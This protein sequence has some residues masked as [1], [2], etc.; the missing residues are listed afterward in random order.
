MSKLIISLSAFLAL[1]LPAFAASLEESNQ[2]LEKAWELHDSKWGL[3]CAKQFKKWLDLKPD[4]DQKYYILAKDGLANCWYYAADVGHESAHAEWAKLGKKA[5]L[6]DLIKVQEI[7]RQGLQMIDRSIAHAPKW[8]PY[9]FTRAKLKQMAWDGTGACKDFHYS[10]AL[11]EAEPRYEWTSENEG[12]LAATCHFASKFDSMAQEIATAKQGGTQLK[13][14]VYYG[15][16]SDAYNENRDYKIRCLV[17]VG[18]NYVPFQDPEPVYYNKCAKVMWNAKKL[19]Y[20]VP[21]GS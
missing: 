17:E 15:S 1:C 19:P 18:V 20:F 9:I 12:S 21:S 6:I 14:G 7:A 11:A 8:P 3:K 4:V 5:S 10:K 2:V 13:P 16:T